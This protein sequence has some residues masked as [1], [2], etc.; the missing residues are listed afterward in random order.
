MKKQNR[1]ETPVHSRLLTRISTAA[2]AALLA[3][4]PGAPLR[5]YTPRDGETITL[6]TFRGQYVSARGNATLTGLA[7]G[8]G[9]SQRFD[10]TL[11][12]DDRILL[13]SGQSYISLDA[14][15]SLR[16]GANRQGATPLRVITLE[17]NDIAL[18]ARDGRF[19]R[20][21]IGEQCQ[22]GAVSDHIRSWERFTVGKIADPNSFPILPNLPPFPQAPPFPGNGND[23]NN[24][25]PPSREG[26]RK[27]TFRT[28]N[29]TYLRAGVGVRGSLA[30]SG[31]QARLWQVFTLK[32]DAG[33][34][35]QIVDGMGRRLV[36]A[37][38]GQVNAVAG[39]NV[40]LR[41]DAH[42]FEVLELANGSVAIKTVFGRY[43]AVQD[44]GSAT[45]T[46][47]RVTDR[48]SFR[49]GRVLSLAQR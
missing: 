26:E 35:V 2:A 48:S 18:E 12:G 34:T 8:D 14:Q 42:R 17:G 6:K 1:S 46:D 16:A 22:L 39:A 24:N 13:R 9:P 10:V 28:C 11:V 47:A 31:E 4:S 23:G 15:G 40:M 30:A 27:V 32:P 43:I 37:E 3:L 5:A 7:A 29:G 33:N 21:G 49:L 44:N 45:A 25:P 19:I 38:D 36:A 41:R 20:A